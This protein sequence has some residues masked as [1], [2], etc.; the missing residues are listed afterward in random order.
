MKESLHEQIRRL[1]DGSIDYNYYVRKGE[2]AKNDEFGALFRR[3]REASI[4][5]TRFL[6]CS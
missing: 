1:P 4:R 3:F 5:A 6:L 2:Q